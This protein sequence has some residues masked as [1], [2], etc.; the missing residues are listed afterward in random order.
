MQSLD[1][2]QASF[3]FELVGGVQF[4]LAQVGER[5]RLNVVRRCR[6]YLATT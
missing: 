6:V 5:I 3:A 4:D 2:D 1:T